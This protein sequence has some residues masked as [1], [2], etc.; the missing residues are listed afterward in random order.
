MLCCVWKLILFVSRSMWWEWLGKGLFHVMWVNEQSSAHPQHFTRSTST[1][2]KTPFVYFFYSRENYVLECVDLGLTIGNLSAVTTCRLLT[3][4]PFM[5]VGFHT[6]GWSM[7]VTRG[8]LKCV[9]IMS[10]GG[11]I[12]IYLNELKCKHCIYIIN[13][14]QPIA[15]HLSCG[16][17][18]IPAVNY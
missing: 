2:T 12:C 17:V 8:S 15:S 14:D 3:F 9:W 6:C 16:A 18:V 13:I 11:V 7:S 1:L 4:C 10:L 5:C